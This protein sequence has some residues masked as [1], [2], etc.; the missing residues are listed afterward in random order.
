MPAPGLPSMPFIPGPIAPVKHNCFLRYMIEQLRNRKF[1]QEL[2]TKQLH[3]NKHL[4]NDRRLTT[5]GI[6]IDLI[7][8]ETYGCVLKVTRSLKLGNDQSIGM[9]NTGR[10]NRKR[11]NLTEGGNKKETEK[12]RKK[13]KNT[14]KERK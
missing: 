5:S 4:K 13:I 6:A 11:E 1:L 9:K 7:R 2:R 10:K 14:K 3:C 8:Q 12:K